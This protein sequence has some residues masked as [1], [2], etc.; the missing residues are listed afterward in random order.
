MPPPEPVADYPRPPRLEASDEHVRI[1]ALG[2]VLAD[3]RRAQ[4]VLETFHPP[5]YYLP[6]D[7][8]RTD[9]LQPGAG[10]SLCEWKGVA[11]YWD[12]QVGERRLNGAIWSYPAPT[13][14]FAAL[15]GWLAFYP[16]AMDG[17]WL[18]GEPV[19]P[20]P[21]GFYGGWITSR[22]QGP[23]KGDPRCPWLI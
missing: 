2:L 8:V 16:A 21:G 3:S 18:D 22:V 17:C 14:P 23:F 7:D 5:T 9:L 15:A 1:E 11:R 13:A 20:Q 4:R 19:Q 12:L 10:R 6:P